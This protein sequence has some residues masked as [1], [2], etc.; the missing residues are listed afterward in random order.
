MCIL[1]F[2]IVCSGSWKYSS[3]DYT[4]TFESVQRIRVWKGTWNEPDSSDISTPSTPRSTRLI[5]KRQ[6]EVSYA[7]A[8][9]FFLQL[10]QQCANRFPIP[11]RG[12]GNIFRE[13]LG[14]VANN[15]VIYDPASSHRE[16]KAGMGWTVRFKARTRCWKW[17]WRRE[18]LN[19]LDP[20]KQETAFC[21][22]GQNSPQ[23]S[24]RCFLRDF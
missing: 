11:S 15:A 10:R 20:L 4:N 18:L 3:T 22:N 14:I 9:F 13:Q 21:I 8:W 6:K 12:D 5:V 1:I 2:F 16:K 7:I 23:K 24:T 17:N 19:Y